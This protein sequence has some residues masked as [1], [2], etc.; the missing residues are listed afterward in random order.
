MRSA[1]SSVR[2]GSLSRSS[3]E[4]ELR[5]TNCPAFRPSRTPCTTALAFVLSLA[6]AS[7]VSCRIWSGVF[8]C[9]H[10]ARSRDK[11]AQAR[12]R[13]STALKMQLV[14]LASEE[15][16]HPWPLKSALD[17]PEKLLQLLRQLTRE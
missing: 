2:P 11:P 1:W 15:I 7:A 5:S 12:S 3:L 10:P 4:E 8:C 13:L 17:F 14:R 6:V 9:V 16:Q